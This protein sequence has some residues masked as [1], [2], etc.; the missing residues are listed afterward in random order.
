MGSRNSYF[1]IL[2]GEDSVSMK[3]FPPL[4][5]GE[6][7][8]IDE[9]IEFLQKRG[10]D[11]YDL[12]LVNETINSDKEVTVRI[13]EKGCYRFDEIME[14]KVTPDKMY[15]IA[16]F[17]APSFNGSR[18]SVEEIKRD[19]AHMKI[20]YGV[21][22]EVLKKHVM[23]PE[24]C[25]NVLVAWGKKPVDG[26][27][28]FIT[29]N[30]NT[31]RRAKPRLNEDGTVDFHELDNISH[32]KKGDVLAVLT[33]EDPGES[34]INVYGS[35]VKPKKVQRAVLR[36]GRNLELIEDGKK[37]VS[38]VD[39][40]VIL[41]G[42][43]VFV[44]NSF[45]VPADVD[46]STGDITYNGN[47]VIRGNV[48]TGFSVKA[49]GDVEVYG[50]VEGAR[51]EAGGNIVLRCGIQGM[52]RG[53]IIAKGNLISKFIESA[54]VRVDGF[55]E[56]DTIL[57]SKVEAK[58]DIFVRGRNGSIIGG[59]V[60]ST[61]LIEAAIIGS[62]MGTTTTVE[63]GTDPAI[64][65]EL[66]DIK[67]KISEKSTEMEKY[68]Q[69]LTLLNKKKVA[70]TLEKD[71]EPMITQMSKNIISITTRIKELSAKYE[72]GMSLLELNKSAKIR[73]IKAVYQG[74]KIA[75]AGDFIL[76]HSELSHLQ[77]RKEKGE[78]IATPF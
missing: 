55:I 40:H 10:I 24:F 50:V 78:I 65:E 3:F 63:V 11:D 53:C 66:A 15:A 56:T 58:G 61:S 19:L 43:K 77:Y 57:H 70:G 4:G 22:E 2:D 29:Y 59:H 26:K 16:R 33:P 54:N 49:E 38:L 41:E 62:P 21:N 72:S 34:G 42:D 12:K 25:K 76:V 1:Q 17:Y 73:I 48:R 7:L 18:L 28:A 27:D 20:T 47:V 8:K 69:V 31:D 30:F 75:I 37:M 64:R 32:I 71:K 44:S 68:Q 6:R 14:V 74:T 35:E 60:M 46:N 45:D 52:G 13:S 36:H 51:I 9:L 5:A 23:Q 39:G 67:K